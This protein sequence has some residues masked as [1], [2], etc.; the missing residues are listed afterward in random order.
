VGNANNELVRDGPAAN[1]AAANTTVRLFKL[2]MS[3]FEAYAIAQGWSAGIR[4]FADLQPANVALRRVQSPYTVGGGNGRCT[5]T[6]ETWVRTDVEY[7]PECERGLV[8]LPEYKPELAVA[9]ARRRGIPTERTGV[10]AGVAAA[11]ITSE[12]TVTPSPT[13]S[14]SP[15]TET[16]SASATPPTTVT[17]T[18][19]PPTEEPTPTPET[20]A[21]TEPATP[22]TPEVEGGGTE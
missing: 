20:P 22:A 8:P 14:A 1:Y 16:P 9:L 19:S 3:T 11:T 18:A 13:P 6:V 12:A 10:S 2:W 5:Q 4:D 17:E 15:A 7:E 21:P